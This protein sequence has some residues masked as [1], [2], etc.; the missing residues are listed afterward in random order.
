M[1]KTRVVRKYPFGYEGIAFVINK[2]NT[3]SILS[4]K[5]IKQL[6]MGQ[7]NSWKDINKNSPLDTVKIFFVDKSNGVMRYISD[8]ITRGAQ[9][10]SKHF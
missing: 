2:R 10:V 3:D 9:D 4:S 5:Q 1:P 7:I 6:I 8:S